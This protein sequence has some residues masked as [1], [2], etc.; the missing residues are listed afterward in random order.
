MDARTTKHIGTINVP[1]CRYVAFKDGYG[2]ITS[3]AG[4]VGDSHAQ[5]GY[6]AKFD[7]ASLQIVASCNVGYQPDELDIVGNTM[8]VAN[9][10]GYRNPG[11]DNTLSIIDLGAFKE[12]GRIPVTVNLHRVRRDAYD[13]VWVSS[14]GDYKTIPSRLYC[15]DSQTNK[16]VDSVLIGVGDMWLDADSLYVYG[17][18]FEGGSMKYHIVDV[19][20]HKIIASKWFDDE[21][22]TIEHPYGV[23]VH[24]VTKEIFLTDAKNYVEPGVLWCIGQDGKSKWS[25]R[26]G[27]IPAHFALLYK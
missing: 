10:G 15:I 14:R 22:I 3:Y 13:Q 23:M 18:E 12:T 5:I 24:P 11:Y 19:K 20:T 9:S 17:S 2:Y 4:Q 27:D 6:V 25:V 26:T 21:K 7:T 1:N 16:V 8:Y